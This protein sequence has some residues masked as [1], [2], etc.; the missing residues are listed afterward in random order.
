MGLTIAKY[1]A[2]QYEAADDTA[3]L[4]GG[5]ND[6]VLGGHEG[7]D[8]YEDEGGRFDIEHS[9]CYCGIHNPACVVKVRS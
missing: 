6:L 4:A 8:E 5:L 7:H 3:S 2:S 1:G 9:C